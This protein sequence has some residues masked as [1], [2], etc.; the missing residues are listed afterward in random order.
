MKSGSTTKSF[1]RGKKVCVTGGAG[2]IGSHLVEELVTQEAIVTVLD[3]LSSGKLRNLRHAGKYRFIHVDLQEYKETLRAL[4]HQ[5]IIFHLAANIGGR[6][7]I[8]THP[9]DC[10]EGFAINQNVIK[11]AQV[12]GVDRLLL[13]SSACVYPTSLQQ[14]YGSQ[15]LLQEKEALKDDWANAD[16]SYGWAKLMGEETLRSYHSQ[17]G[18]KGS[19]TRYVT[20]YGPREN[21]SHAIIALIKRALRHE[22]P[23]LVWGSGK[24]DRDFTFVDD[25]VTGTLLV[26]EKVIDGSAVNLGTA[27]RYTI[28]ETVEMIF[29]ILN[30][31]PKKI[32]HDHTQ[33]EGVR[34]R[35][36]DNKKAK[37]LGWKPEVDLQK[38]LEATI[39]WHQTNKK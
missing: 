12:N 28:N 10:C 21:D 6:G 5:A 38:G 16:E 36:L 25:I 13:A 32:I 3:N 19:V 35:A 39:H 31:H 18:L 24:Q 20:A 7:Y 22:D 9:A 30:W 15:H 23:F 33:P 17:Y 8:T 14:K 4:K 29:N 11:A 26:G 27:R 37:K 2:F 1:Y 34:T